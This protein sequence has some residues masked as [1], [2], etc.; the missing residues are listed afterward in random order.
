MRRY[1]LIAMMVLAGC[2]QP[3][4]RDDSDVDGDY[5][6]ADEEASHGTDPANPDSDGDSYVD[7]D[8]VLEGTDP[9]DPL[10][11]IYRGGWP[12]QRNKQSIVDPGFDS[13]PAVGAVIPRVMGVDQYGEEVDL[14][15]FALHGR[16]VVIDLSALW[17]TACRD[18]ALWLD[19]QSSTFDAQ[20]EFGAIVAMVESGEIHWIT[21]IFEDAVGVAAGPE[22]AIAWYE[23]FPNPRIPVLADNDRALY[24]Y[25]F[26]GSMPSL[27][28]LDEDMTIRVYDRYDYATALRSLLE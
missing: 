8:E 21:V 15:D 7:G 9:L 19:G 20:Q 28:V 23:A 25:L 3:D 27:Q 5:L 18:M 2:E 16:A 10:S 6:T 14:Y 26:P 22:E 12:Y 17:C 1:A 4:A 11:L 24:D 13:M